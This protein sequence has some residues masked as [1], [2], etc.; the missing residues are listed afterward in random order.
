M[1]TAKEATA[2]GAAVTTHEES[3]LES[4]IA[5]TKQTEPDRAHALLRALTEQALEGTVKFDRNL[6][7][8]INKAI[9]AANLA[10]QT[11]V[12]HAS[13]NGEVRVVA[14]AGHVIQETHPEAVAAAVDDVLAKLR[15]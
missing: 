13:K 11:D 8:S 12:A 2:P 3:L 9:E 1:S 6:T 10:L 14:G 5:A 7:V 4:V 15:R